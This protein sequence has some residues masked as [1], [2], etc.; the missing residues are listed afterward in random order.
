MGY[1]VHNLTPTQLS[2][3]SNYISLSILIYLSIG[4]TSISLFE[5]RESV[6]RSYL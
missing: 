5:S 3:A 2:P 6:S 4:L 1:L